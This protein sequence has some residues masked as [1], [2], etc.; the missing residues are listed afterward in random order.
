MRRSWCNTQYIVTNLFISFLIQGVSS[1]PKCANVTSI[2]PF[3]NTTTSALQPVYGE[4]RFSPDF[5][6]LALALMTVVSLTAFLVLHLYYLPKIRQSS[7]EERESFLVSYSGLSDTLLGLKED[8][9]IHDTDNYLQDD[10]NG[11]PEMPSGFLPQSGT[12]LVSKKEMSRRNSFYLIFL[13]F[14]LNFM[15]NGVLPSIQSTYLHIHNMDTLYKGFMGLFFVYHPLSGYS[16]IPYGDQYYH[17][18]VSISSAANT[19][20]CLGLLRWGTSNQTRW[21]ERHNGAGWLTLILLLFSIYIITAASQSP[22]PF[23]S[24]TAAGGVMIVLVWVSI[25]GLFTYI[26]VMIAG[27]LSSR[28]GYDALLWYGKCACRPST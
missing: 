4:P 1:P 12:H 25:N 24:G 3:S 20:T 16:C 8:K 18:S 10:S 15:A 6:F 21:L 22:E 28:R 27:I 19:L 13:N 23:L 5:F 14:V 7:T 9:S 11:E 26:K 2:D 17:L